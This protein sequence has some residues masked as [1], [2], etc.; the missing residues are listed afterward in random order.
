VGT[1]PEWASQE[2]LETHFADHGSRLGCQSVE[3]YER[4]SKATIDQGTFFN[5]RDRSTGQWRLGYYDRLTQRFT[6]VDEDG[7]RIVTH[8]RCSESY[9]RGLPE[10][11]Y[12]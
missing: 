2:Q 3:E 9:I 6:S 1:E 10:N 11:D 8:F 7:E 5:Y 12:R 4:S